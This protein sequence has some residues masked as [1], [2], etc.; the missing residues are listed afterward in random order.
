MQTRSDQG[1]LDQFQS[2]GRSLTGGIRFRVDRGMHA[3]AVHVSPNAR[4][5]I[6]AHA[7]NDIVLI[8]D[9][10]APHHMQLVV[11]DPWRGIIRLEAHDQPVDLPD[12]RR[13]ET[14]HFIDAPLPLRFR[15]G[16]AECSL[17]SVRK[18]GAF[19]VYALPAA[20][21]LAAAILL[22]SFASLFA[23]SGERFSPPASVTTTSAN[24]GTM[25]A[26]IAVW[27]EKLNDHLRQAGLSGQVSLE[28]G[29]TGNIVAFGAIEDA[30]LAKWRDVL[31]WYDSLGGG[32]LLINN[33]TRGAVP[34][35][36]PAIKT[37]WLDTNPQVVLQNGQSIG[38]GDLAPG[39]WKIEAIDPTGVLFSREGRTAKVPF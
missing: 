3:G 38:V 31:K 21:L 30:S 24:L 1:L 22:P 13:I 15:L 32:P 14:G 37:V 20:G 27:Q 16:G 19:R 4:L 35:N 8:G 11:K 26:D 39:G 7:D 10:L 33:V 17:E 12:G 25:P 34:I 29:S 2:A 5:K 36:L 9:A 28:R 6:G 18:I 23:S